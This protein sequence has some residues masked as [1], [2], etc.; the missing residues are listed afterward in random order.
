M[1][2]LKNLKGIQ[3]LS[4]KQL[5]QVKGAVR[6]YCKGRNRCCF[7]VNG[8]EFCEPGHCSYNRGCILY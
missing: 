5:Q 3:V 7:Q 6:F 2:S 1:K 4:K 8:T